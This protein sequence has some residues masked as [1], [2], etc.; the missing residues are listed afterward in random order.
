MKPKIKA[1]I[2]AGL[3]SL[4]LLTAYPAS[5]QLVICG[6]K[7]QDPVETSGPQIQQGGCQI[8]DLFELLFIGVNYL[9]GMAGFVAIFFIVWGGMRML[10]AAGNTSRIDDAKSTIKHAILGLILTMLAYLIV[11]YVAGL[12]LPG[13]G[14]DP[15]RNLYEYLKS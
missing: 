5:A 1:I 4:L 13:G 11:G 10:L 2:A 8:S 14:A 6:R 9:I 12:L 3:C 7:D 15:V